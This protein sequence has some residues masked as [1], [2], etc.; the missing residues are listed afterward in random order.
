MMRNGETAATRIASNVVDDDFSSCM[1][2]SFD[3]LDQDLK[4]YASLTVA[5]GQI[6]LNPRVTKNIQG[7]NQWCRDRICCNEDPSAFT[8]PVDDVPELT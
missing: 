2:K 4:S 5:N 8:F 1:D 7:F 6:R 3:D